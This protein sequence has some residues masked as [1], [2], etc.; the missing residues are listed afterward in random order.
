MFVRMAFEMS[1]PGVAKAHWLGATH[2]CA[3]VVHGT[4]RRGGLGVTA[5][6]TAAHAGRLTLNEA[7]AR[8]DVS[9]VTLR[10]AIKSGS[11]R[12]APRRNDREPYL[13]DEA[14][15]AAAGFTV[16]PDVRPV[17]HVAAHTPAP[18]D[19]RLLADLEAARAA[20]EAMR[21]ERETPIAR[22][23]RAE[24]EL[25]ATRRDFATLTAGLTPALA[26][27]AERPPPRQVIDAEPLR[28]E[29]LERATAPARRRWWQRETG[30]EAVS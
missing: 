17:A 2:A 15:L 12:H 22:V 26:A 7:A 29:P 11:L 23:H 21:E 10:R 30:A 13:L 9:V 28:G 8:C 20:L 19:S 3:L 24:G 18:D 16:H 1:Q 27:L 14:A 6:V 4:Y 25:A 5:M